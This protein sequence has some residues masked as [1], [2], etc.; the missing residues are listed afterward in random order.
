M[1]LVKNC[2][3]YLCD[4]GFRWPYKIGLWACFSKF[5]RS[6]Y[7]DKIPFLF[8]TLYTHFSEF[9]GRRGQACNGRTCACFTLVHILH[10]ASS[11]TWWLGRGVWHPLQPIL[12]LCEQRHL[13]PRYF[14]TSRRCHFGAYYYGCHYF[15]TALDTVSGTSV[16]FCC[17]VAACFNVP[18]KW[19]S[20]SY[21]FRWSFR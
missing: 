5:C 2:I 18:G 3:V 21:N 9:L 16:T 11:W 4:A 7:T 6:P 10:Q 1:P 20:L 13:T 12:K 8:S 14:C 17:S 15:G 19:K